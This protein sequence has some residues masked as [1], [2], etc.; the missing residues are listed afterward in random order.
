MKEWMKWALIPVLLA[1]LVVGV[2]LVNKLTE[3]PAGDIEITPPS[4]TESVFTEE[5]EKLLDT[6]YE[7]FLA[8]TDEEK[9]A[10]KNSFSKLKA[11]THWHYAAK[12]A[13][14]AKQEVIII[15]P[16]QSI[17]IGELTGQQ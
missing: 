11:Y 14:D 1:V 6:T 12:E 15:G 2:I 3:K 7:E 8:M 17:D 4:T 16:D 5:D 10:F 13:Y 9:E